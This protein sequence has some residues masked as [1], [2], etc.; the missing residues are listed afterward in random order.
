MPN[1]NGDNK[2]ARHSLTTW[3]ALLSVSITLILA[4][5]SLITF[6]VNVGMRIAVMETDIRYMRESVTA[7]SQATAV[8]S[9]LKTRVE[10]LERLQ[11][12]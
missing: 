4:L 10:S 12:E 6:A 7:T 1:N 3:A 5:G 8:M 2:G 9:E 11:N